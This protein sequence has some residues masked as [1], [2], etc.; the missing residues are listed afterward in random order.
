MTNGEHIQQLYEKGT[1]F[2]NTSI[3]TGVIY[4]PYFKTYIQYQINF[5]H[6]N[7]FYNTFKYKLTINDMPI[8]DKFP[9]TSIRDILP[10][11]DF[12]LELKEHLI[13]KL[14][15]AIT[16]HIAKGMHR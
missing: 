15:N 2:E 13:E 3:E 10:S 5:D 12:L 8:E 1:L 4:E 7:P 16:L 9:I 14:A 11:T 6:E